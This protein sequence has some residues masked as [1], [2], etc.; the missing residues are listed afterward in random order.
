MLNFINMCLFTCHMLQFSGHNTHENMT[1][2]KSSF[3]INE[4]STD[5]VDQNNSYSFN[6]NDQRKSKKKISKTDTTYFISGDEFLSSFVGY[7][8]DI[9]DTL[10]YFLS[11]CREYL[12]FVFWFWC[13]FEDLPHVPLSGYISDYV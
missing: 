9:V 10:Q 3:T 4:P 13:S 8:L 11:D 6:Q 5:V 7:R 2:L 1:N 12:I